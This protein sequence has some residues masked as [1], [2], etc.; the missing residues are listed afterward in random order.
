MRRRL[1]I[2]VRSILLGWAALFGITYLVERPLLLLT[3]HF[4]G[5]SWLPTEQLALACA[6][7][8]AI[9][10]II[11]RWNRFDAMAA[12]LIFAATL[13]IWNV[14]LVPLDLPWLFRLILDSFQNLRYLESLLTA[15]ATHGLL[16][17]S[18]LAGARLSGPAQPPVSIAP[19][20]M[21]NRA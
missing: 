11:G 7:L 20:R 10:W 4:I 13:A 15:L 12:A 6:G 14:G 1:V 8:A 3:A 2:S 9:G 18:L 5:A 17:G 19:D 16:F 21:D